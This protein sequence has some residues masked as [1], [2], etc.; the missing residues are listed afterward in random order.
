MLPK[1]SIRR[2]VTTI[3]L[4][5]I[6]LLGGLVSLSSL[7]LD[8][9]PNVDVPIVLITTSYT[10]AGPEEIE[11]LL[12]KP[13]ESAVST[14]K[15]VD[16]VTSTSSANSSMVII[17]F[18][19]GADIDTAAMDVR[20][21]IDMVRSTLP[22][23][24]S[25]PMILKIDMSMLSASYVGIYSDKLDLNELTTL[26]N[27]NLN[28]RIERIDGV[29]SVELTGSI[30][31]EVEIVIN[32][33]KMQGYG[34]SLSQLQSIIKAE[35]MNLPAG[36][37][38]QGDLNMQIRSVGEF[39]S[40][41]EIRNLPIPTT[42]GGIVYMRDIAEVNEVEKD[43]DSYAIVN[44]EKSVILTIQKQS[45]ANL[46]DV[47]EKIEKEIKSIEKDYPDVRLSMLTNTSSY[48]KQSLNNVLQTAI[49]AAIMAVIVLIIFL[50]NWKTSLVIA[51]SIPTSV[52]ATFAFMYLAKMTLNIISLGGITIG[53]GMLVDNSVVVLENIS[54]HFALGKS[55]RE[56]AL[57][58]TKE[59]AMAIMA[60]TLTTIAVFVPL[61]FVT[62]IFGQMFKDLSLTVTCSLLMSLFVSLTFVPM[63]C[64]QLFKEEDR[65]KEFKNLKFNKFLGKWGNA[66][67]TI[68]V[69]YKKAL[70]YSL[71]HK[72]RIIAIV[73]AAFIGTMCLVPI[74]GLNLIPDMDQGSL[75]INISLPS[76]SS[77]DETT[78]ITNEVIERIKDI[79]ETKEWYGMV[80]NSSTDTTDLVLNFVDK[81]DR[82]RSTNEIA[83][84]IKER[85]KGLAG[86]E[87]TVTVSTMAMGDFSSASDVSVNIVG[88]DTDELRKIGNDLVEILNNNKSFK[89]A[90]T[91]IDDAV[92]ET[93]VTIDR[94]KA[95]TYGI[96]SSAIASA[97]S[98]SITG[99]T[100]S[101]FKVD[102]DEIDITL[103]E[104]KDSIKYISDLSNVKIPTTS[105]LLVP[106]T[107]VADITVKEGAYQIT[108]IDQHKYISVNA[109]TEGID[110]NTAK[111]ELTE[112]LDSYIFPSGYYYEFT[113][114]LD[115]LTDTFSKLLL[116]LVVAILLVYM[117]MASQFESFIYP[118]I[119]MFSLPL[120]LTG[121]VFGLFIT[122]NTI[123]VT[124]FMGFIMLTGMV[125]NNAI[126]LIDYTNQLRERGL[127]CDEALI[128]AGPTRLRPILM[129]T[130]TTILGLLPMALSNTE[131]TEMQRPMAITIMFGLTISTIVTLIFIPVL[132]SG[133][134]KYRL[135]KRRERKA[136]KKA[137]KE[138]PE[139]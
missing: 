102:G 123:T 136:I 113:G 76:G 127:E 25:D 77:I 16:T 137:L 62:G 27:D 73:L 38:M 91:S 11:T 51:V 101:Q 65:G 96:T 82:N 120:G 72:K 84:D 112:I 80:G 56:A 43:A 64:S 95:S 94:A 135:K 12:T 85:L 47:S 129:T 97:L 121:S 69:K 86:A 42:T 126:V 20:E 111:K 107:E 88:D 3:M 55:P 130:L 4:I 45:D 21:K 36:T 89:E 61:M 70:E 15:K 83:E 9:M 118:L 68:D 79:P 13:I 131:G 41:E 125:V 39:S 93:V 30:E 1:I 46:V 17:Q 5:F 49:L 54:R 106:L 23:D 33:E 128:E 99:S 6:I 119:V 53:I 22:S 35:N 117:I 59:V 108:R 40:V 63:A 78:K 103:R 124:S 104:E 114:T 31:H 10:G 100:T 116:V 2:P 60:S 34:V 28:S 32:N 67:D 57:D 134:E 122:R 52:V 92:P 14:V 81:K 71:S 138:Q 139:A 19:D 98:S 37:I 24:A 115:S 7:S 133:V 66:I 8:L 74:V 75:S 44:G 109:N 90:S 58:G 50:K 87:T 132:Y 110:A 18:N 105:G 29:A 48:I 26:L